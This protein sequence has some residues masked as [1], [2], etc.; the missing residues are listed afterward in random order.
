MQW[1]VA[2]RVPTLGRYTDRPG[3]GSHRS[4]CLTC[5]RTESS[6]LRRLSKDAFGPPELSRAGGRYRA[7]GRSLRET[8]RKTNQTLGSCSLRSMPRPAWVMAGKSR[9]RK[10]EL[11]DGDK[12]KACRTGWCNDDKG[13]A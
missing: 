8:N 3:T 11:L 4:H 12:R 6:G 13:E 9:P 1:Q 7:A 2:N 10:V 5:L